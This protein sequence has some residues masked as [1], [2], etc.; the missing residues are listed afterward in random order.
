MGPCHR[1]SPWRKT[2]WLQGLPPLPIGAERIGCLP[3]GEP[4][5]WTYPP[6]QVSHGI[7]GVLH[8]EEGWNP[9]TCSQLFHYQPTLLFIISVISVLRFI[10]PQPSRDLHP[11]LF[12]SP[13]RW[14]F[15]TSWFVIY[16]SFGSPASSST[17]A[18]TPTLSRC[19]TK[20]DCTW[21]EEHLATLVHVFQTN[22]S[23]KALWD[24]HLSKQCKIFWDSCAACKSTRSV[25]IFKFDQFIQH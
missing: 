24:T 9:P 3:S 6:V 5:V 18:L 13:A 14:V 20:S 1:T 2:V 17:V 16:L 4:K 25:S 19:P 11:F 21:K 23:P 7:S 8:Q 10:I 22:I 15:S 12:R